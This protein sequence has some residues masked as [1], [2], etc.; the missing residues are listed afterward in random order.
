MSPLA[1]RWLL[2]MRRTPETM[3]D[4]VAQPVLFLLMFTFL[5]GGAIAG[6]PR[7]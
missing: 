7:A 5:F 1:R 2:R 3:M 4:V 6:S